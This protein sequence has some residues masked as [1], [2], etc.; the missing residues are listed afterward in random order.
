MNEESESDRPTIT[1]FLGA[2]AII[3]LVVS[4]IALLN[5]LGGDGLS[6]DQR[7]GR[8]AVAQNDA[9]QRESY[10][11][12]LDYTCRE[13]RSAEAEFLAQQRDSVAKR[14]ARYVDDVTAVTIEGD[15]AT[16]TVVYHFDNAPDT[17]INAETR[18]VREDGTWRVCSGVKDSPP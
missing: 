1:P 3:V 4:G 9:M 10:P 15:R 7:V 13:Q 17:K 5:L 16:G 6:E 12:Y 14:G 18:F 8:A 11:E 2:L